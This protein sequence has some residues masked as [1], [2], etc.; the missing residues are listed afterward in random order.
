MK[1]DS[2]GNDF[3]DALRNELVNRVSAQAQQTARP[4]EAVPKSRS[5]RVPVVTAATGLLVASVSA[6]VLVGVGTP[7]TVGASPSSGTSGTRPVLLQAPEPTSDVYP[8]T[9]AGQGT[10]HLRSDGCVM[11]GSSVLIAPHGSALVDEGAAVQ[12]VGIGRYPLGAYVPALGG[13][14]ATYTKDDLPAG[15]AQCG[16]GTYM[17]LWPTR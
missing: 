6:V 15:L 12:L 11:V 1:H 8:A 9:A 3:V 14:S 13:M 2:A 17:T 16:P 7:A 10:L 5:W 4:N